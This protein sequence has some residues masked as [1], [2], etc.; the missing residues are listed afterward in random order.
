MFGLQQMQLKSIV[1]HMLN[2]CP[3]IAKASQ[4]LNEYR[5]CESNNKTWHRRVRTI[6]P[7]H[8]GRKERTWGGSLFAAVDNIAARQSFV[9]RPAP[10]TQHWV[11]S[12]ASTHT[13]GHYCFVCMMRALSPVG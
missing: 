1:K 7:K 4:K 13:G 3:I 11:N 8:F 6:R 12:L 10:S 9:G 2:L 5:L